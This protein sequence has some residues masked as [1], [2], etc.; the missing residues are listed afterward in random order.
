MP[1]YEY[2]CKKCRLVFS[3]LRK[4]SER[5]K[6]ISCPQCG[7]AAEVMFSGFSQVSGSSSGADSCPVSDSCGS[8][9]T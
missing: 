5:E 2:K 4:I 9:F 7:A 1:L 3:E 8:K 6:K